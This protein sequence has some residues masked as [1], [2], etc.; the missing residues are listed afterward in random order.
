[1][2]TLVLPDGRRLTFDEHGKPD[3][4]LVFCLH[5]TPG[6]RLGVVP[7]AAGMAAAGARVVTYDRPGYG[8]SDRH[9]G[10]AVG[11]AAAD[12]AAIANHLEVDTF[13]VYGISGGGPHALACAALLP[14]RVTRAASIVGIAPFLAEGLN[15]F[16][17]M[18]PSNVSEF[19]AALAGAEVLSAALAPVVAEMATNPAGLIDA[20]AAEVP[21]ADREALAQPHLRAMLT[22]SFA[23]AARADGWV[24]D[25][26]A[27]AGDWGFDPADITVSTLIWHG[28]QDALAPVGH[29]R[30]L[31]GRIPDATLHIAPGAGHMAS[32]A[33]QDDLLPWLLG[34]TDAVS[35]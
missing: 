35:S 13:S 8:A 30:W 33:V 21:A 4:R 1:M 3:H 20:L 16:A 19:G 18:T 17:G 14:G 9:P 11:D 31:A 23:G 12:V 27:F 34:D 24:D 6:S 5:G 7:T 2:A 26:L 10:R 22:A 32:L 29:S 28:A 15:W 25:D